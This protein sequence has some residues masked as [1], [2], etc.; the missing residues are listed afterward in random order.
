MIVYWIAAGV[1]ALLFFAAGAMKLA[2][3]REARWLVPG[4]SGRP[5]SAPP[6]VPYP[7]Y[8]TA[9]AVALVVGNS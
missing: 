1:T 7:P 4:W 3:P 5:T 6:I 8:R 2:R 9:R